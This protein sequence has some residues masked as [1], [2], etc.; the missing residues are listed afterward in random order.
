[1]R[2]IVEEYLAKPT[3]ALKARLTTMELKFVER[4]AGKKPK[5]EPKEEKKPAKE[6]KKKD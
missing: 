5:G 3:A 2:A 1:M 6:E 4:E